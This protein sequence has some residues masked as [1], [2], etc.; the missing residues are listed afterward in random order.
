MK[1]LSVL[2]LFFMLIQPGFANTVIT[3]P[4]LVNPEKI[5]VDGDR[6]FVSE[7][8]HVYIY[9]LSD[10]KLLKKFGKA[11][12]GPQEFKVNPLTGGLQ[13]T[14]TPDGIYVSTLNKISFFTREGG[15]KKEIRNPALSTFF[16]PVGSNH[17]GLG[18]AQKDKM[19]F[20]T[21]N[22]LNPNMK[23]IKEIYR[24]EHLFQQGKFNPLGRFP[25]VVTYNDKFAITGIKGILIFN[26]KGEKE[27]TV[28]YTFDKLKVESHHKKEV[29]NFY[30]KDPR[31]K[32]L[33]GIFK[34]IM[35]F[36]EYF[37]YYQVF[38]KTEDKFYVQTYLRKDNKA[39]F[40]VFDW[41]GKPVKKTF[42]PLTDKNVIEPYPY[43]I[44]KGKLY[45]LIEN[46][47][48][49]EWELHIFPF[50]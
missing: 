2:V 29:D 22:L 5:I 37:S 34:D 50:K 30:K 45:Q 31:F 17:V 14:I 46:L 32:Q 48:E 18:F 21:I 15:F 13:M 35:V 8:A 44:Y 43:S 1:K 26:D 49:E 10:F 23:K 11:G 4:D 33:Y 20:L 47:D 38:S 36:P 19:L 6:F 41:K 28:D 9:N 27:I 3:L 12:E 39:Q 16:H 42:A 7:G 25:S 40:I 24:Q